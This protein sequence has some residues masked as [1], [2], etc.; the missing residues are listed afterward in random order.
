MSYPAHIT[1]HP[2][3]EG[4]ALHQKGS[5]RL[6]VLNHSSAVLWCLL[7]EQGEGELLI[8]AYADHFNI[9]EEQAKADV[10]NALG[11][12]QRN[13]LLMS[14][15]AVSCQLSA[16]SKKQ[17]GL[18]F[19]LPVFNHPLTVTAFWRQSYTVAGVSWEVS[20]NDAAAAQNWLGCFAHLEAENSSPDLHYQIIEEP[21]GWTITGHGERMG[22]LASDQVLPWLLTFLFGELCHR[23]PQNLLLHAAVALRDGQLLLL[24]GES[25]FGKSTLAAALAA[26][27]WTLYSD[28][29]APLDP[30]TLQV[31]PFPL[32]VVIKSRSLS[33]LE[34][35]YPQLTNILAHRRADGQLVR[36]LAPPQIGLAS[37]AAPSTP[38][39]ALIFPRFHPRTSTPIEPLAPLAALE[40]LARTGSSERSLTTPDVQ[41]LLTLAGQCPC[42]SL[43]Y[44]DLGEA[45]KQIESVVKL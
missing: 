41:A 18:R 28:E 11:E 16:L 39:A 33:A 29:L 2:F 22:D 40:L 31:L 6:W 7:E 43:E 9:T 14:K 26:N 38:V 27:G 35:C 23:Q 4:A 3:A 12:F 19:E 20:C 24:P 45:V 1:F 25:T 42:W 36:Y 8:S 21:S 32:P 44:F 10:Q 5:H 13:G 34:S 37:P 17:Q 15:S 30:A